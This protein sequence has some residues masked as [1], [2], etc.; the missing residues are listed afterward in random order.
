ME[1]GTQ[2][3][4]RE[5]ERQAAHM[6]KSLGGGGTDSNARESNAGASADGGKADQSTPK[7]P[8]SKKVSSSVNK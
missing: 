1:G 2:D 5:M 6:K 8:M 4:V 7:S 3:D